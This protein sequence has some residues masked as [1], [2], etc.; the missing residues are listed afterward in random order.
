MIAFKDLDGYMP[1]D[2]GAIEHALRTAGYWYP[3]DAIDAVWEGRDHYHPLDPT[4]TYPMTATRWRT[5]GACIHKALT[6][7]GANP[8]GTLRDLGEWPRRATR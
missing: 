8:N 1:F 6:Q 7:Q 5:I 2:R 3:P 4:I